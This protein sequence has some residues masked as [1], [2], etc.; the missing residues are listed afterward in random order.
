M[1]LH[2][3]DVAARTN[4][5]DW[6][7]QCRDGFLE[8]LAAQGYSPATLDVYGRLVRAQCSEFTARG[9]EIARQ[10][11][12]AAATLGGSAPKGSAAKT[13]ALWESV[14]R[15]FVR[16]IC[17]L[18][19]LDASVPET[20]PEPDDLRHL[21]EAYEDWLRHQRGLSGETVKN[22][23]QVFNAFM[24]FRF[25]DKAIQPD[26][27]TPADLVAFLVPQRT[28]RW[29]CPDRTKASRL[30]NLLRFLHWSGVGFRW[31]LSRRYR[32]LRATT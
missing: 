4:A 10:E 8:S 11:A 26:R 30:R 2:I 32:A 9:L 23:L 6:L 19:I 24:R 15:R 12:A 18:G 25:T 20:A 13:R 27:V 5:G 16:Y 3:N 22:N 21:R 28:D 29:T 17:E 1:E 14:A 7:Q 31:L